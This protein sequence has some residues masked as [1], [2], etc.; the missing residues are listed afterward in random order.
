MAV[1]PE[2]ALHASAPHRLVPGHRVLHEAGEQVSVVG[3]AVG[4]RGTVVE[5]VLVVAAGPCLHR[6]R[7]RAVLGPEGEHPLFERRV[8][9]LLGDLG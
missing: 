6:G 7:E 9:R 4:E 5:D 2:T 8:I 1:P 3:K